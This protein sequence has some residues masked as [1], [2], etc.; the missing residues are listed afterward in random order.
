[1]RPIIDK[2]VGAWYLA[3]N[4]PFDRSWH[5]PSVHD[6]F[7]FSPNVKVGYDF[8]KKINAGIEYYGAVG[9]ATDFVPISLQQH[10]IFPV[11]DLNLSPK[12][13]VNF[14]L[15]GGVTR[16]PDRLLAK[17]ILADRFPFCPGLCG[18][19]TQPP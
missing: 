6:G 1:M 8:T 7:I 12:W 3:F 5:G 2:Q 17:L 4:L 11:V 18:Q 9:P 13:E 19:Q 15:G 16:S 10:Q 14:G